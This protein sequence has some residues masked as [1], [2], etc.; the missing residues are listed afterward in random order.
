MMRM[1]EDWCLLNN[2]KA[3]QATPAVVARFVKDIAPMG[4]SRVWR[5]VQEISRMFYVIGLADPT[6]GGPVAAAINEIS[7]IPAPRSWPKEEQIRFLTLPY[8]IQ[9]TIE[10][11]ER[12]R[13]KRV[14]H[15][16]NEVAKIRKETEHA[17]SKTIAEHAA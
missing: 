10:K 12:D 15:L 3:H 11:R 5:A 13:D 6:L 4:I 14:Q 16:Q 1:F 7:K 2:E 8:D 9:I 17:A